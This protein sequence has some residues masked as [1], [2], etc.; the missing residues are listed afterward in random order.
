MSG[1]LVLLAYRPARDRPGSGAMLRRLSACGRWAWRHALFAGVLVAAA[2]LRIVAAAG[3]PSMLWTGDS[4]VYVRAAL[5]LTPAAHHPGGYPI[6]LWLLRPLHGFTAVVAAQAVMGLLTG[7]MVYAL[8]W[9]AARARWPHRPWLPQA[10]GCAASIPVLLDGDRL[11][12]EHLLVSD[13]LF[14]FLVM[15]AVTVLLWR[16]PVP[17]WSAGAAG[18]LAGCAAVTR[19]VG[20]PLILVIAAGLV[21]TGLNGAGAG[22][23]RRR[24]SG[25]TVIVAVGAF[26]VPVTAY[27]AWFHSHYG[28]WGFNRHGA[29][30]LYGRTAAF[31]DCARIKP[32]PDLAVLC[33]KRPPSD[34]RIA[35]PVY[36]AMFS[37]ESPFR[38][39]GGIYGPRSNDLARRFLWAAIKA[40]PG[41]YLRVVAR[42]TLRAFEPGRSPYPT[43]WTEA[44]Y[45]F[46]KSARR[47]LNSA[48]AVR[49]TELAEAYGG[50]TGVT[51]VVQPYARWVRAYQ[52][53]LS[54]P[55]PALAVLMLIPVVGVAARWR[56]RRRPGTEAGARGRDGEALTAWLMAG[57]L[58]VIPAASADYDPRYVL[59]AIPLA[60]LAAALTLIPRTPAPE[61]PG[62]EANPH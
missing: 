1:R 60:C 62:T 16:S 14:A 26:L 31:A 32:A 45:H 41:D 38:R 12:L 21:M 40:Q 5:T 47:A 4:A 36:A 27:M 44:K 53:R 58:L 28:E 56:Q 42:D 15:S 19:I 20:L 9:R 49:Q 59:P 34:P 2:T 61:R 13:E 8:V 46:P 11:Q 17:R 6:L 50:A 57:A 39:I 52:A 25:L 48:A 10:L 7:V 54:L 29:V 51:L 24:A 43:T 37:K 3:Y 22:A 55:G 30:W 33:P 23:W 18:L 35:S